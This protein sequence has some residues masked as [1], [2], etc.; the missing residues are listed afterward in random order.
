MYVHLA[1]MRFAEGTEPDTVD[2]L[3]DGVRRMVSDVPGVHD[4]WCGPDVSGRSRGLTH[5]IVVTAESAQA[6]ESYRQ[7]PAHVALRDH[8]EMQPS[9]VAADHAPGLVFDLSSVG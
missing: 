4:I 7:H 6:V 1:L 2:A 3:L 9:H 5:A 8:V